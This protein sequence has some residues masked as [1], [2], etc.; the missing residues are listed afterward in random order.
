MCFIASCS[1]D[2]H[3][4]NYTQWEHEN[5]DDT[6]KDDS[7]D[8]NTDSSEDKGNNTTSYADAIRENVSATVNYEYYNFVVQLYSYAT[9][10]GKP[11]AGKNVN[12][13]IEWYYTTN[14]YTVFDCDVNTKNSFLTTTKVSANQYTVIAPVFVWEDDDSKT[15]LMNFYS[16]Q[17]RALKQKTG[18]LT[19]DEKKIMQQLEKDL[20]KCAYMVDTYRGRVYA[21]VEGK[22]YYIKSFQK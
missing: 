14:P 9:D 20:G 7:S 8:G 21:E 19:S 6:D 22:R 10:S 5:S 12:Y 1:K 2:D 11:L 18:S 15:Y 3:E 4:D 13:G 17:Y 16:L